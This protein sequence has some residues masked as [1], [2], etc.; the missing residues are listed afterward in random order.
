MK[1]VS[2]G[3]EVPNHRHLDLRLRGRAAIDDA[4]IIDCAVAAGWLAGW[5]VS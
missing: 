4:G 5:R 2:S 3:L 1:G